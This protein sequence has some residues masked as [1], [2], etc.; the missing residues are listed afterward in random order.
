MTTPAPTAT[1]AT[2]MPVRPSSPDDIGIGLVEPA[3]LEDEAALA[4]SVVWDGGAVLL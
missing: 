2:I 3:A 1:S 4:V